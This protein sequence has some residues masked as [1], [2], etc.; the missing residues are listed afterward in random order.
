[1]ADSIDVKVVLVAISPQ[2][3]ETPQPNAAPK[4]GLAWDRPRA[5][6]ITGLKPAGLARYVEYEDKIV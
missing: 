1:L 3:G 4:G 2:W 6:L 5:I